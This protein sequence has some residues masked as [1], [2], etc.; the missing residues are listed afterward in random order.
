MPWRKRAGWT[1]REIGRAGDSG[2][3]VAGTDR[4]KPVAK[5]REICVGAG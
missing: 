5:A 1:K 4:L 3:R 2:K